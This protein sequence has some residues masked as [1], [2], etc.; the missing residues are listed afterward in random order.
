MNQAQENAEHSGLEGFIRLD[1][2]IS[3]LDKPGIYQEEVRI[4]AQTAD[5]GNA[6]VWNACWLLS[7]TLLVAWLYGMIRSRRSGRKE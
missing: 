5:Y 6:Y 1:V 3:Q 4:G 7:F 2:P